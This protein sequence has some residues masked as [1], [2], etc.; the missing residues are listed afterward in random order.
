MEVFEWKGNTGSFHINV[1]FGPKLKEIIKYYFNI[2]S[3]KFFLKKQ[4]NTRLTDQREEPTYEACYGH[5]Q[6][7]NTKENGIEMVGK[8]ESTVQW[9][10][11]ISKGLQ[12]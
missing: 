9:Q 10:G 1:L 6:A 5:I 8:I 12:S 4:Q 11:M 2:F 3:N 7:G